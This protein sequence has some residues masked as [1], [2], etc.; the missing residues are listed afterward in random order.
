M[1]NEATQPP[2]TNVQL[3]TQTDMEFALRQKPHHVYQTIRQLKFKMPKL[4]KNANQ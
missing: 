1:F 4:H 3:E 2:L